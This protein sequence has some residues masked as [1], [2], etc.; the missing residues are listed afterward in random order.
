MDLLLKN[1]VL[2]LTGATGGIG[3]AICAAFLQEGTFVV[4]LYRNEN[5]FSDLKKNLEAQ[6]IDLSG[7]HGIQTDILNTTDIQ[8]AVDETINRHQRIDIL[9]N[10]A[11]NSFENHFALLEEKQIDEMI[12]INLKSP[13]LLSQAV[14]KPMFK[15]KEGCIIN[16]STIA[17]HK[18]GRG[19]AVYAA[20]KAG[21]DAFTRTLAQEVGKKNIRVNS[22]RPGVIETEMSAPLL[23]R[24]G[25]MVVEATAMNR[26]GTAEDIAAA[27][28]FL[29]SGKAA[30]FIT[31]TQL[32]VDGGLY[33]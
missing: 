14:L 30:S 1:K 12:S 11:G 28:V 15:Q 26:L 17:A 2:L 20:A 29:A 21:L 22:I 33:L 6:G 27:A 5:R 23:E 4:A 19:I 8:K 7:F 24:T 13:M 31:G 18:K 16:I 10:C 32:N 3:R 9:I 25:S